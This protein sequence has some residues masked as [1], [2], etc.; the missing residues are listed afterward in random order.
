MILSALD[1]ES[2]AENPRTRSMVL[3]GV[4]ATLACLALVSLYA[5]LAYNPA[6]ELQAE[7]PGYDGKPAD[8]GL[9]TA[10]IDLAGVFLASDGQPADLPG[11][12]TSFRGPDALNIATDVPPLANAWP[13]E[14]PEVLWKIPVGDGYAAP[15]VLNGRVYLMDYDVEGRADVIRCLSLEDGKEIW[16]RSYD[17]NIKRNHGMSRTIP[18]VTERYLVTV[19]PKCHVVCLDPESGDFRWG[20]D[21]VQDFG[22]E[23]PLWYAGQCPFIDNDVAVIAPAGSEALLIGVDCETGK[24]LWQTP[25]PRGWEMSHSSVIPMTILGQRIYV[26]SALGGFA[27]VSAEPGSEGKLLFD[28]PWDA[29]VVAP[30][31]VQV[32][33][34]LIFV[35]AGY[36]KGS[37]L[38]KLS[39]TG[40]GLAAEVVY[41]K[42]PSEILSCE[43][44]TPIFHDGLIYGILP[45]AAGELNGQFVCAR[46]D[47]TVVWTSGSDQRFGLGP[48]L[49]ADNKFFLLDDA[50]TL[51]MLDATREGYHQLGRAEILNGHDAWGPLALAGSRLLL[52]DMNNLACVEL[53]ASS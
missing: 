1:P 30:S 23:V 4:P 40:D 22:T 21:L 24:V 2:L 7:V 52:R 53:G 18:A 32:G 44:Q 45:K 3:F 10:K 6:W 26:Y 36:G 15:A 12:W 27:A 19:G 51:T 8:G 17:V 50:G 41:D 47:G 49:K 35:T 25:N 34:D 37:R 14:G 46:P 38:L 9:G 43:Q 48:F 31:P 20:I 42:T 5:W 13:A 16:R 33:E 39:K 11:A 29:K 28:L